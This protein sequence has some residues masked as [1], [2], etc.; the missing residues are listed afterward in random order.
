MRN[1]ISLD[2][3]RNRFATTPSAIRLRAVAWLFFRRRK[4]SRS[5]ITPGRCFTKAGPDWPSA[6]A[7]EPARNL[8]RVADVTRH[9][10][11]RR[12]NWQYFWPLSSTEADCDFATGWRE[13]LL[14]RLPEPPSPPHSG[15]P[16][17][18]IIGIFHLQLRGYQFAI[19]PHPARHRLRSASILPA[20]FEQCRWST[21]RRRVP[22]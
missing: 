15:I 20:S 16:L 1:K 3:A 5:P 14:S 22:S 2:E 19:E 7:V 21:M 13:T 11:P 9:Q 4:M 18:D 10:R 12:Q 17:R 6:R 8:A